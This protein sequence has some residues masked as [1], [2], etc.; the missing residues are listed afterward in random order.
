MNR[1]TFLLSWVGT[2][3][4]QPAGGLAQKQKHAVRTVGYLSPQPESLR[5]DGRGV[6]TGELEDLGWRPGL[7]L[8]IELGISQGK[9]DLLPQFADALVRK[10]VDVILAIGPEA[11]VAAASATRTIPIV[12]WAVPLPVEQG[13]VESLGRPGRN[14][15][16]YMWWAASEVAMKQLEILKETVPTAERIAWMEVPSA[17]RTVSGK[18][19]EQPRLDIAMAAR[20]LGVDLR[21]EVVHRP[22]DI[23]AAFA[24]FT[25]AQVQA[26]GIPTTTLTWRERGRIAELALRHRLPSAHGERDCVEA[27]GLVSYGVNWRATVPPTVGYIDRILRGAKPAELPVLQPSKYDLAVNLRTARALGITVP[28]SILVR[29]SEVIE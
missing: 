8:R 5:P 6:V 26:I 27:G 4:L 9:E 20:H 17:N 3:L 2:A 16:G 29:A 28:Q 23:D 18:D 7:N 21:E 14:A 1:R 25:E 15:T 22:E 19:L 10:R 13:L 12:F 24:R 11:A